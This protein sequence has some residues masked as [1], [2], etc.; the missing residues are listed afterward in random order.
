MGDGPAADQRSGKS[1]LRRSSWAT[2][3]WYG[4]QKGSSTRQQHPCARATPRASASVLDAGRNHLTTGSPSEFSS[5]DTSLALV[6]A[7]STSRARNQDPAM[8]AQ[9]GPTGP[10]GV[11]GPSSSTSSS[12]RRSKGRPNAFVGAPKPR[13]HERTASL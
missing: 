9:A 4:L 13:V 8:T 2:T 12:A 5:R 11:Q 7:S 6:V 10:P 3:A 1:R